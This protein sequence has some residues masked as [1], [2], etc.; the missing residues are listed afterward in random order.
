MD[1][2][3]TISLM[4]PAAAGP[5]I[6]KRAYLGLPSVPASQQ[7][8]EFENA[9]R[10]LG[11]SKHETFRSPDALGKPFGGGVIIILAVTVTRSRR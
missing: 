6:S 2:K 1:L 3:H 8:L 4:D 11:R 5:R 9:A 10:R 7:R